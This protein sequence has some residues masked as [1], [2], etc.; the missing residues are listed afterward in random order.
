VWEKDKQ[1]Q[2]W[3]YSLR[4]NKPTTHIG[5]MPWVTGR[6]LPKHPASQSHA[7]IHLKETGAAHYRD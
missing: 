5:G 2:A 3:S 4:A 7:A 6:A 1:K